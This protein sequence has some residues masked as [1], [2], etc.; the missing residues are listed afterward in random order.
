M[1]NQQ[2]KALKETGYLVIK[3]FLTPDEVQQLRSLCLSPTF[4]KTDS[5]V[6]G[7][8]ITHGQ[9]RDIF[10][11][12]KLVAKLQELIGDDLYYICDGSARGDDK[13]LSKSARK[14]HTDSRADDFDF[15]KDYPLYRIG[16]YLQDMDTTSGGLKLRPR[17]HKM[18]CIDHGNLYE[19]FYR[20]V[21]YFLKYK[22]IPRV[23]LSPGI[24]V[25]SKAGDLLIWNMRLHHSGHAVRL[26]FLPNISLYPFMENL[27]PKSWLIN[28]DQKRCVL[29]F[30]FGQKSEYLQDYFHYVSEHPHN[31]KHMEKNNFTAPDLTSRIESLSVKLLSDIVM[32]NPASKEEYKNKKFF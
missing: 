16:M 1:E 6:N 10:L 26:K 4:V 17:S 29:F 19:G 8:L 24:N 13:P 23:N 18:L 30:A 32:I 20:F 15:S 25:K 11:S 28:Q 7:D 9:F 5:V 21:K 3:D 14:Y 12:P 2:K 22:K 31:I 27:V